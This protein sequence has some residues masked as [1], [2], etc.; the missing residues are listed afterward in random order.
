MTRKAFNVGGGVGDGDKST[1]KRPHFPLVRLTEAKQASAGEAVRE[2]AP[3]LVAFPDDVKPQEHMHDGNVCDDDEEIYAGL[4]YRK[5]G[6]L[7]HGKAPIRTSSWTCCESHPCNPWNEMGSIGTSVLC[8]GYDVAGDMSCP[9]RPGSCLVDEEIH[10]GMCYKR[11]SIL[12]N[13][14]FPHRSGPETCC[15]ADD[16]GCMMPWNTRLRP[17]FAVGGGDGH[18]T[19]RRAHMPQV[20]FTE[21][22]GHRRAR[23]AHDDNETKVSVHDEVA[24]VKDEAKH[25]GAEVGQMAS[26]FIAEMAGEAPHGFLAQHSVGKVTVEE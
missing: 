4:C 6:L 16:L 12:T 11:C 22:P 7:T 13:G 18:E 19:P 17:R 5:C 8:N 14:E 24:A 9:H 2:M 3:L 15:K 25:V 1:P 23:K 20:R 21:A 10:L 26:N